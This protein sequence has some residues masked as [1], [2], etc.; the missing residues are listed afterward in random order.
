M[1]GEQDGGRVDPP[2]RRGALRDSTTRWMSG[3][4]AIA[5]G[6]LCLTKF[7]F[8]PGGWNWERRRGGAAGGIAG[9]MCLLAGSWAVVS[10]YVAWMRGDD[11]R[12]R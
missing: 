4:A 8:D 6:L 12:E 9:Y 3:L 10:V 11:L 1:A 2:D 5:I 7:G